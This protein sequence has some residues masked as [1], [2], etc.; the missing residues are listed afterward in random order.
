MNTFFQKPH[1]EKATCKA[2]GA[3]GNLGPWTTDRYYEIDFCLARTRWHNSVLDVKSDPFTNVTSDHKMVKIMFKQK[4]KAIDSSPPTPS[5]KG[6]NAKDEQQLIY[7][8]TS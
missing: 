2:V 3:P 5:L 8:H 4:L 7:Y 1:S 6:V